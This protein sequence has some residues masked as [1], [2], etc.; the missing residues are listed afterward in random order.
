MIGD[1][2]TKTA[3]IVDPQRDVDQY[4]NEA[5]AKGLAIRH[6]VLTHF[7]ADFVA[8]HLELAR[9]TGA[10]IHLGANAHADY[11]FHALQ[12]GEALELGD[13]RLVALATPGHTPEG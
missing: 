7:H 8:G 5:R 13:V 6:V 11:P 9:R 3:V 12:D 10:T 4:V 1:E 2:R